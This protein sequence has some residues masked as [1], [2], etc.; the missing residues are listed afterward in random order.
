MDMMKFN[1]IV[2]KNIKNIRES[3]NL[4]KGEFASAIMIGEEILE[5]IESGEGMI[6]DHINIMRIGIM[7][8]KFGLDTATELFKGVN[9]SVS[10]NVKLT[11]L[12][13]A[14]IRNFRKIDGAKDKLL[15]FAWL[16]NC[17]KNESYKPKVLH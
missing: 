17:I 8:T 11:A 13:A 14:L 12:E 15:F 5:E 1:E 9:E 3:R 2:G 16:F 7:Q 6:D 10:C 4:S